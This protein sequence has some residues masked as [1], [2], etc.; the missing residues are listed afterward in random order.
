MILNLSPDHLDR[1]ADMEAY[2]EAKLRIYSGDGAVIANRDDPS[3]RVCIP[4]QRRVVSFGLGAPEAENFGLIVAAGRT[5]LVQGE[6]RLL[7]ADELGL[8]GTHN[9]LNALAALALG[10]AA[11]LAR[12]GLIAALRS[13]TGLPHRTQPIA[14][15]GGVR[16][17]NFSTGVNVGET[18]AAR[19]G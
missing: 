19:G 12:V 2:L 4:P 15:R 6:E 11:G 18:H 13:F 17:L 3:L 5:W 14:E 1:Y 9:A 10:A 8:R 16:V 7:A